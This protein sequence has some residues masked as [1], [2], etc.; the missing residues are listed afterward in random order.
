MSSAIIWFCFKN[1][2]VNTQWVETLDVVLLY[3]IRY[4]NYLIL[5]SSVRKFSICLC[6]R[7]VLLSIFARLID[8]CFTADRIV[9]EFR[10]RRNLRRNYET[11]STIIL[12]IGSYL[13]IYSFRPSYLVFSGKQLISVNLSPNRYFPTS[14]FLFPKKNT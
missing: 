13:L 2:K 12:F 11:M 5:P 4:V 1:C 3:I 8:A 9:L 14:S 10:A 6:K 7:Y